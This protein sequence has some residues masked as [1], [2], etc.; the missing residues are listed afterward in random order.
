MSQT[1][2]FKVNVLF[3]IFQKFVPSTKRDELYDA[4]CDYVILESK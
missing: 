4:L 1:Q 3:N 2:M